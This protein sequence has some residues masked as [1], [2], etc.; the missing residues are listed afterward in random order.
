MYCLIL[1]IIVE[2]TLQNVHSILHMSMMIAQAS[3]FDKITTPLA[4]D[5][6]LLSFHEKHSGRL[7]IDP[8]YA[9][10]HVASF[11]PEF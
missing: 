5:V 1:Y 2:Y 6:D 8:R 9:H 7:V 11:L 3:N 10:E 4:S